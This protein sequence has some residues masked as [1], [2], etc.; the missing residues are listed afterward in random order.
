MMF[1]LIVL[2]FFHVPVKDHDEKHLS[3]SVKQ[4]SVSHPKWCKIRFG[5]AF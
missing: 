4:A 3:R 1:A 2:G 5:Y